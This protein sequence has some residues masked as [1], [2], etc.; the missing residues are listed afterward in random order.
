MC[1]GALAGAA[2]PRTPARAEAARPNIVHIFADD[3]GWGSVGFNGQQKIATPNLDEL[4]A[5]GMKFANAYSAP[6]CAPSR[7]MLYTGFHQ[8]HAV[9]DGNDTLANNSGFRAEDVMTGEVLSGAG[10]ATGVFGKW[11]FGASQGSSSNPPVLELPEALPNNH[12]FAEF[13]GYLNHGAAHDYFTKH[14]WQTNPSAAN[15][16]QIVL[17]D[18]GP[19]NTAQYTHDLIAARSEQFVATHAGGAEPFYL[20]VNYTIPHTDVNDIASAPGGYGAYASMPGWTNEQKAYAA[21]ISRMDKTVGD[22]VDR[23]D[24]P[25]DDGD[26]ADSVLANTLVIFTAD[27]GGDKGTFAQPRPQTVDFF[28]GNGHFR[29]GKF[30]LFEGGIHIPAVAYWPGVIE[31]GSESEYRTDLA[32]FMATIA[33][34]SGAEAPVG[35]DGVSIVPTLTGAASQRRREYL[36]F[37]HQGSRGTAGTI[38][39]RMAI[40]RQ[41]G[42]KL[43]FYANESVELFNLN[44]DPDENNPLNLSDLGN[45]AIAA[46]MRSAA[47]AEGALR[48]VVEYRTYNGANGA[49]VQAD[50][51]WDGAGRPNGYWSAKIANSSGAAR[52]AHVT[53]DVTTL[54]VEVRGSSAQQVVDVHAGKTLE[55]RNEV[56]IGALGRVD[57]SGGVLATNRRVDIQSGGELRGHGDVIGDLYNEGVVAPGRSAGDSAWPVAPP[58][59]LPSISL[60]TGVV[61]AAT[62]NFSGVQDTVP[63]LATTT[64]NPNME[65][66]KGLDF[67]PGVS[68][69]LG[70]G[71]SDAGNEFNVMGHAATSLTAAKDNGDYVSFTVDP[72]D[73]AGM[74]PSSVSFRIWRN[75][76]SAAKSFAILSSLDGFTSPLVQEAYGSGDHTSQATQRTITANLPAI[77]A[78]TGPIEY[79]L[80]SWHASDGA[81]NT[82]IN[83]A[84]LNARFVAVPTLEFNFAGVQDGAPL[85]AL[86]RADERVALSAG[87]AFGPGASPRDA[88]N[89][90]NE[91]HVAGLSTGASLQS[92]I[93]S[94]DYLSFAVQS[95]AGLAMYPDSVSFELWRQGVGSATDYAVLSSVDGFA[96][97]DQIGQTHTTAVGAANRVTVTGSFASAQPTTD[98]VEYRL[99][100]WNAATSLDSTHLAGASMRARFA[101]V[102]G[103]PIDPTGQMDIQGDF[104]H[105]AG[106]ELA[107]DL[108]GSLQGAT[109]DTVNVL[110]SVDL[111]GDLSITL[112]DV[113]GQPFAPSFGQSF[114]I[115]TAVEGIAGEFANVELPT[116]A[117]G[118]QWRINYGAAVVTLNVLAAADFNG[119]GNVDG[120][121]LA[122][123]SAGFGQN[124]EATNDDG[125]ANSDGVVDGKDFLQWQRQLGMHSPASLAATAAVPEPSGLLLLLTAMFLTARGRYRMKTRGCFEVSCPRP[126]G[127]QPGS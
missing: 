10:Y 48:G 32:D 57:L 39:Q 95:V 49:N 75:G 50:S 69:K 4:A 91:F 3:F 97:G 11:G 46:E 87:L 105:L 36:V 64:L 99:Y 83:L 77:E 43:I 84:S 72:I 15:G 54:G 73:G 12:G 37:E 117:D 109:Y 90:G 112:A 122:R 51:S 93:D 16:V 92:A 58:P 100:G 119:D 114:E 9:I 29:G 22:L 96:S 127:S 124:G 65:I 20:Q 6:V 34:L 78:A 59:A 106:G 2:L 55:G 31:A 67:G 79:R 82:H 27:N 21:M 23:L 33:D 63:L 88:N 126:A 60:D 104:N 108:G 18:D 40:V 19:G 110:G 56:R 86:K 24:D 38:A 81:G 28:Q 45:A 116:L 52:I 17:N 66:S 101:S 115:L 94:G 111:K 85:T 26:V 1:L 98:S 71:G 7:A 53:D 74:I 61:P 5:G 47:V 123:W 25:N 35:V 76:T 42:M 113:G 30:E 89:A 13:Y 62:F 70:N 125:D 44:A 120:D 41:D 80:Y 107:I 103:S 8:G 68:P 118:L 102:I 121:D 14:M